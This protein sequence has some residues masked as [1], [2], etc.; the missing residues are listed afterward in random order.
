MELYQLYNF[1]A[2][3][4]QGF[5]ET[6][7]NVYPSFTGGFSSYGAW[8]LTSL[9]IAFGI[10]A[11]LFLLQAFG[12]Y[13]MAKKQNMPKPY[14]AFI[15]FVSTWYMSKLAGKCTFFGRKMKNAGIYALIAQILSAIVCALAIAAELYLYIGCSVEST[16]QILRFQ[17]WLICILLMHL[18]QGVRVG[19]RSL[20]LELHSGG[21]WY[22]QLL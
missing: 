4:F 18:Q 8:L 19:H 5:F 7:A 15:P 20:S 6:M 3:T 1:I 2:R 17:E 21:H 9:G 11:I 10:W 13:Y 14:L 16:L 12:L 22:P